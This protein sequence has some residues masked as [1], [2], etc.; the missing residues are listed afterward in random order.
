M[1]FYL[2]L[3]LFNF[4]SFIFNVYNVVL[5]LLYIS[6]H[7]EGSKDIVVLKM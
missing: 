7:W 6:C 5:A 2:S 3:F 4:F 1:L